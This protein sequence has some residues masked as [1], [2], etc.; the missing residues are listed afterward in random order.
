MSTK[1]GFMPVS[2]LPTQTGV[3]SI[4]KLAFRPLPKDYKSWLTG[5]PNTTVL[6]FAWNLP[7]NSGYQCSI[8]SKRPAGFK[9]EVDPAPA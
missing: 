4:S 7:V 2:E 3:L 8:S 1:P 9:D 6:M 5:L